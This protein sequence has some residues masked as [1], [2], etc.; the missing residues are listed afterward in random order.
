MNGILKEGPNAPYFDKY[1]TNIIKGIALI[2]M[3]VHHFFTF[4]S[5]WL[6]GISYPL[7]EKLAPY[8]CMPLKLCVPIFCFMTGY[9]YA[10]NK[11]KSFKYS[12]KKISDIL[13]SY[14]CVFWLFAL[15][16]IWGVHYQYTLGGFIKECFALYRPTMTFC[17]YVNFYIAF[18]LV[19]PLITK[20]MTKNIHLDLIITFICMPFVI[21]LLG[22]FITNDIVKEIL[23]NLSGWFP[24]VLIGYIFANY[25]LFEKMQSLN[26]YIV[27]RKWINIIIWICLFFI[28]PMGRFF[29]PNMSLAFKWIPSFQISMDVIYAPI[30]IYLVV[31]LTKSIKLKYTYKA[32]FYIGKYSLLMWFISCI[33]YNNSRTIFQPILYKPHNPIIV[34]LWGLIMCYV[35]A[36]FLD[37]FITKIQRIKNKKLFSN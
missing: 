13:I 4:P 23:G 9:F 34:T 18:M 5:W 7:I 14:W 30:F 16:A 19:L 21:R 8:F 24:C 26:I 36:Y 1:T 11:S 35:I 17:W 32:M 3:F 6:E 27:R 15:V 37:F 29:E 20:I 2:M 31:N 25:K 33:F 28:I 10:F 22:H 12:M